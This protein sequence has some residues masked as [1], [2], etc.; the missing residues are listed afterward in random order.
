MQLIERTPGA[1]SLDGDIDAV[2]AR[3]AHPYSVRNPRYPSIAI[4][5]RMLM[6]HTSSVRDGP[7]VDEAVVFGGDSDVALDDFL[8][9]YLGGARPPGAFYP[10]PPGSAYAYSNVGAALIGDL[11]ELLAG[12]DLQSYCR[13]A[14]F[15]PLDMHESSWF[16]RDLS[17]AHIATPYQTSDDGTWLAL[18]SYGY[19]T[20]PDGALRTSAVQ[21]ARFLMAS[22]GMGQWGAAR[23]LGPAAAAEM[24]RRQPGSEDGLAW[25]YWTVGARTLIGHGGAYLGASTDLWFDPANR[26]GFVFL[27]NG[28]LFFRDGTS[29][30]NQAVDEI[31]AYLLNLADGSR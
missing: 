1:L 17:P 11:V 22:S 24:R 30:E 15:Q 4:T 2:T 19:P 9:A 6:S 26:A 28:D 25:R 8:L 16:L 23:I 21:L 3:S 5:P 12:E 7:E 13:R 27:S 10:Y 14:I 29:A 31:E 18:P 20:Y